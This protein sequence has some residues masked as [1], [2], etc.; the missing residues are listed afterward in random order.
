ML[1]FTP[2]LAI[3]PYEASPYSSWLTAHP[4]ITFVR[5]PVI[6]IVVYALIFVVIDLIIIAR[7]LNILMGKS[8]VKIEPFH[9][10]KAGG[11][12][13]IGRFTANLS[14]LIGVLGILLFSRILQN[15]QS[16]YDERSYVLLLGIGLYLVMAP[17]FFFLPL[18]MTHV[19]MVNFRNNLLGEIA[20][21]IESAMQELGVFPRYAEDILSKDNPVLG[22]EQI[23]ELTDKIEH[24]NGLR[25]FVKNNVPTWP[26][27]TGSLRKFYGIILAPLVPTILSILRD[28]IFG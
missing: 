5:A 3:S 22:A 13:F 14:Y 28:L 15:P 26:F 17:I 20:H 25:D 7:V 12:G 10:D 2:S 4:L 27:N 18:R 1:A 11:L 9:P 6:F 21:K 19:A 16:L 23:K 8:R 24:F